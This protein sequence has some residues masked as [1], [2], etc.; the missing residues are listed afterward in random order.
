MYYVS[1]GYKD[2]FSSQRYK[3]R[4]GITEE[5]R[6]ELPAFYR[7]KYTILPNLRSGVLCRDWLPQVSYPLKHFPRS[8]GY[9]TWVTDL[10]KVH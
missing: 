1:L 9:L 3:N 4:A 7:F 8:G 5:V 6:K 10:A 2:E